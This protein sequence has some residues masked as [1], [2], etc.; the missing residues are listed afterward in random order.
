[1][2]FVLI[3]LTISYYLSWKITDGLIRLCNL[4][5]AL[6]Y[7]G[8]A[9]SLTDASSLDLFDTVRHLAITSINKLLITNTRIILIKV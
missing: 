1:M 6:L 5:M 3:K 2:Y 9:I 7:K 4:A 8:K